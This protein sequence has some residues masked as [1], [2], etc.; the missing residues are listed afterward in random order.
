M[1]PTH[2]MTCTTWYDL[3]ITECTKGAEGSTA[4]CKVLLTLAQHAYPHPCPLPWNIL[5]MPPKCHGRRMVEA[6][7]A[8]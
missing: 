8:R 5:C 7:D 3:Q 6:A 4:F 1:M 2:D